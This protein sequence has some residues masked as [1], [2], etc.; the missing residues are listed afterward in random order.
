MISKSLQKE[1]DLFDKKVDE[2]DWSE[3]D[4]KALIIATESVQA[5]KKFGSKLSSYEFVNSILNE[6]DDAIK[7]LS[8]FCRIIVPREIPN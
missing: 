6:Y 1:L 7:L 2:K 5:V 3:E 8:D 4:I